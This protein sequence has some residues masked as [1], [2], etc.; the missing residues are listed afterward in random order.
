MSTSAV[1]P[2]DAQPSIEHLKQ[3]EVLFAHCRLNEIVACLHAHVYSRTFD[4]ELS[5]YPRV[6]MHYGMQ[7]EQVTKT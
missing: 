5:H 3:A 6:E 7:I 4:P 1:P 2:P